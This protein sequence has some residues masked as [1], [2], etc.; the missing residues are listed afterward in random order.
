MAFACSRTK[1]FRFKVFFAVLGNNE[2]QGAKNDDENILPY[3][4]ESGKA[5][6]Y[7]DFPKPILPL[8]YSAKVSD[9][10][11]LCDYVTEVLLKPCY[12]PIMTER[13]KD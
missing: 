11:I 6:G 12:T 2:F 8:E 5:P 7:S 3:I 9:F 4:K 13:Y 1:I 10:F